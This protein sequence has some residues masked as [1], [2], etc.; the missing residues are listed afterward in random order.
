MKRYVHLT[1]AT[2]IGVPIILP[3]CFGSK[4]HI[5]R[6]ERIVVKKPWP[7]E[8][9]TV[10]A[11]KSKN[12]GNI[13]IEKPFDE[14]DDW[15]DGFTVTVV[16]NYDRTVTSVTVEIVFRREPGDIR[17]P[18]SFQ[19]H[20]GPSPNTPE[21]LLRD[22]KNVIA[23]GKTADLRLSPKDYSSLRGY[24]DQTGYP[25]SMRQFGGDVCSARSETKLLWPH[26]PR[27][28]RE[29]FHGN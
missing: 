6:P 15:L 26:F 13:E 8:P 28:S 2:L 16:N 1:L 5:Q 23:V 7:V 25:A 29:S 20:M 3:V 14:E 24:Q 12:R 22:P 4:A 21:Y 27:A 11:A 10:S 9:V 18:F 17:P 19:L